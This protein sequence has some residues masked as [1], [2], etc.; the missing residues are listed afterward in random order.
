MPLPPCTPNTH[1]ARTLPCTCTLPKVEETLYNYPDSPLLTPIA[2]PLSPPTVTRWPGSALKCHGSHFPWN[3][4]RKD[5]IRGE[6]AFPARECALKAVAN[7][8]Q[9]SR[10][11]AKDAGLPEGTHRIPKT[12]GDEVG[13]EG[14]EERSKGK[15]VGRIRTPRPLAKEVGSEVGRGAPGSNSYQ[16]VPGCGQRVQTHCVGL[17][18]PQT[19]L[20]SS[21]P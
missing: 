5:P 12:Q 16:A 9:L 15:N 13:Q 6:S 19:T 14:V 8:S 21:S 3:K 18:K 1:P 2:A 4:V 17:R 11:L 7:S 20:Q 10:W